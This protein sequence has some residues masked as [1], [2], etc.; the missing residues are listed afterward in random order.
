[1]STSDV[2]YLRGSIVVGIDYR[3]GRATTIIAGG[4][5]LWPCGSRSTNFCSG[6][7]A[8]WTSIIA[9]NS[10][11]VLISPN[12]RRTP[13]QVKVTVH[14]VRLGAATDARTWRA[15]RKLYIKASSYFLTLS[16]SSAKPSRDSLSAAKIDAGIHTDL[17]WNSPAVAC[18][19]ASMVA[20]EIRGTSYNRASTGH[21]NLQFRRGAYRD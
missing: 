16:L 7:G 17:R 19:E 10:G 5:N 9:W 3:L 20:L 4:I 21:E 12:A 18:T 6:R 8:D 13:G 2:N 14:V 1:M 15:T 11:G